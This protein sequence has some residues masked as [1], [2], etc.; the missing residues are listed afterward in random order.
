MGTDE[1]GMANVLIDCRGSKYGTGEVAITGCTIQHNRKSADSA[2][3]RIYGASLDRDGEP[4]NEGNVTITGNVLSDV[5]VNVHLVDC[6]G[7]TLTGNTF[8]MGMQHNLLCENCRSISTAA[9]NMDRNPRYVYG[10]TQADNSVVFRNCADSTISGLHLTNVNHEPAALI[11]ENCKRM[12]IG[13]CSVLDCGPV[14][15]LLKD[16]TQSQLSGM[17]INNSV[18]GAASTGLVIEGGNVSGMK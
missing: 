13:Q 11:F 2:N 1:T 7:V 6:R 5:F 9:N 15:V 17:L 16:C 3:I 12:N 10:G 18:G 14:G 8:W 4:V